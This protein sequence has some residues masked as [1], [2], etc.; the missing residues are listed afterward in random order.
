MPIQNITLLALRNLIKIEAKVQGADNLDTWID[1]LVNELLLDFCLQKKYYELLLTNVLVATV[2][3]QEAYAL[4]ANFNFM[5]LVRYQPARTN[6]RARTLWPR[7][8]FVESVGLNGLPRFYQLVGASLKLMPFTD[9][10]AN[11]SLLL[12]YYKYPDTLTPSDNIPIP[13]LIAPIKTA[14]IYRTHLYN[15]SLQQAAAF[16][17]ESESKET[18]SQTPNS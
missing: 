11:D 15:N 13:R 4:P 7:N 6:S 14:A 9:I 1:A 5:H 18:R 2:A 8:E 10:P 12:D 17:K 16:Q 3:G